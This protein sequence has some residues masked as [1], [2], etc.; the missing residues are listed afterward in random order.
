MS[1]KRQPRSQKQLQL[2]GQSSPHYTNQQDKQVL[3]D[4]DNQLVVG[5]ID[6]IITVTREK[7]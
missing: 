7:S 5:V 3:N 4:M 6:Y 1:R 2:L